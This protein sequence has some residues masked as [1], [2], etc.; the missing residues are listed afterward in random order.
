MINDII[1]NTLKLLYENPEWDDRYAGYATYIPLE[2]PKA[3]KKP[4]G[5]SVYSS[6]SMYKQ[7]TYDLRFDGQSVGKLYNQVNP[8][9][10]T[11]EINEKTNDYF[12]LRFPNKKIDWNTDPDAKA[13]RRFFRD[14]AKEGDVKLKSPEHRVKH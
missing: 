14:K 5:L 12:Q 3:F 9:K 11:L 2:L 13:F 6:V 10:V 4:Q 8:K 7:N 1:E